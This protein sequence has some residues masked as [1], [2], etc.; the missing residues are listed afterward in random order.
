MSET[1]NLTLERLVAFVN[2]NYTDVETGPGS[3]IHE[4]LLKLAASIQNQQYNEITTLNQGNAITTALESLEDTYSPIIDKIASNYNTE[5]SL[6]TIVTGKIKVTVD[7]EG[8]YNLLP[9]SAVFTQPSLGLNYLLKE[10]VRVTADPNLSAILNETRLYA[11]NGFYYFII[12]VVAENVGEEYQVSSGTVFSLTGDSFIESFVK[13]EAYG[14]FSSGK[15][16]E[17]DKKLIYKIKDNLGNSRFESAAGISK[18]FKETFSG[19]QTLSVCGAGDDE[20]FRSKQ[21]VFGISTFGKADIYV[22][23]SL[24][25]EIKEITKEA[26]KVVEVADNI[27]ELNILNSDIPGF[28]HIKSILPV[29]DSINLTGTLE[30]LDIVYGADIY[31]NQRNNEIYTTLFKSNEG[32]NYVEARFTKYQTA[33]ITFRYDDSSTDKALFKVQ[34][35]YQPNILEMQ[36]LLLSDNSRLACA[37]YLVKAVTPCIVT[38]NIKLLKNRPTDTYES[39]NLQ[40]LKKDIFSYVNSIPF[41]QEL[42]ASSLID[43]C[44]NYNIKRV[45]LPIDMEGLILCPDGTNITIKDNDVLRIPKNL[46][47]RIT[48]KTT[49]YFIDYFRENASGITP[50]DSIGLNII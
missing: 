48:D 21:N 24:G 17:T 4:L 3:V 46:E 29:S 47:K 32:L 37:D 9:T 12:D 14:N 45:D 25:M 49:L 40:N 28:Y 27:W 44:H 50:S 43:L 41:G 20:M 38:L 10:E 2:Q 42:H 19:I 1:L 15:S 5:R 30:I 34:A 26:V 23:S 18:K 36:D 39:L 35:T 6:G 11:E 33:K 22:R 7:F 13:A 8:N 31:A 16:P